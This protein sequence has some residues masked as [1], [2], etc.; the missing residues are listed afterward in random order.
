MSQNPD[1]FSAANPYSAPAAQPGAARDGAYEF[2]AEENAL[3]KKMTGAMRF[4]GIFTALFGVLL[5]FTTALNAVGP[6]AQ[7]ANLIVNAAQGL[8]QL[9]YGVWTLNAAGGFARVVSTQGNDVQHV[10]DALENLR[11]YFG[12]VRVM[13]I[14]GIVLMVL[15]F[16]TLIALRQAPSY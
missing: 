1:T 8:V 2:S 9:L 16:V 10:M 15:G 11:R 4:V 5:L 6:R 7:P 14:V 12:L 13:I 3:I